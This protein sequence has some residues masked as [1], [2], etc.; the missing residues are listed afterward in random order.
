MDEASIIQYITGTFA[1]VQ[2]ASANGDSFFMYAP[3]GKVPERTLPFATLVTSDAYDKVSNLD[4]PGVF[5][6]NLGIGKAAY[7]PLFG[8]RPAPPGK[9]GI[10]DTGH[11]FTA[12]DQL[13][14]HPVYG[15]LYWICVLNP[16]ETTFQIL[17][18]LLAEAYDIAARK[19]ASRASHE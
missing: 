18:P 6:L 10:I 5:R 9:S 13:M 1:D 2:V 8:A 4:R 16:S 15:H 7:T 11:D 17:R 12:L 19:H 3:E 14:P